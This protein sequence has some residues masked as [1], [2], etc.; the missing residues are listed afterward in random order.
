MSSNPEKMTRTGE[1]KTHDIIEHKICTSEFAYDFDYLRIH[2]NVTF[3]KG[4]E[5]LG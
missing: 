1:L 4:K 2:P 3:S 5:A